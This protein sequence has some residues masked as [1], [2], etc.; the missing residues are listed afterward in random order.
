MPVRTNMTRRLWNSMSAAVV[1][2]AGALVFS[3]CASSGD[4]VGDAGNIAAATT[5]ACSLLTS[6]EVARALGVGS[7][8]PVP[9]P[10]EEGSTGC[11]WLQ[12]T[13]STSVGLIYTNDPT[14][15][16]DVKAD[17]LGSSD[18][19]TARPGIGDGAKITIFGLSVLVGES[20]FTLTTPDESVDEVLAPA[21]VARLR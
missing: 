10:A 20:A 7:V 6:D 14:T 13:D 19:S 8:T 16:A 17:I 9:Y 5:D 18:R 3:G 11:A 21:V 4:T 15:V 2:G 12:D 1:L